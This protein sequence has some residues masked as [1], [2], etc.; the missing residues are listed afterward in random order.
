MECY[1]CRQAEP[2]LHHVKRRGDVTAPIPDAAMEDGPDSLAYRQYL[3]VMSYRSAFV[4]PACYRKL[5][6]LD[7]TAEIG[8]HRYAHLRQLRPGF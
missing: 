6:S 5:D 7:G 8:G 3:Q 1:T 2:L 4:C